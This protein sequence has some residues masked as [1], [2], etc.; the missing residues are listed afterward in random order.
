M[1]LLTSHQSTSSP[2]SDL[3]RSHA[4]TPDSSPENT[5]LRFV[6]EDRAAVITVAGVASLSS[7][8]EARENAPPSRARVV[9]MIKKLLRRG[10][11]CV[12]LR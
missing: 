10:A 4:T 12:L 9:Q 5:A 2:V 8:G 6:W 7:G 1:P 11:T 3:M